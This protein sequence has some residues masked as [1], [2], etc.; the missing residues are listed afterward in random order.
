MGEYKSL[1]ISFPMTIRNWPIMDY[2]HGIIFRPNV[3]PYRKKLGLLHSYSELLNKIRESF[4]PIIDSLKKNDGKAS[5]FIHSN[6]DLVAV[7]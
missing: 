5:L 6:W 1:W 2:V 4:F 3:L 7:Y